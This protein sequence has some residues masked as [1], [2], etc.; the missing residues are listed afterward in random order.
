MEEEKSKYEHPDPEENPK[1]FQYDFPL[2]HPKVALNQSV[3]DF[4]AF[5]KLMSIIEEHKEFSSDLTGV[6]EDAMITE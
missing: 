4:E 1:S 3:E 6:S 5:E 2:D